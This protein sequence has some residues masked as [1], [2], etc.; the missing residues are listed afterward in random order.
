MLGALIVVSILFIYV[1]WNY[2]R[3]V[4]SMRVSL[5]KEQAQRM[6]E[7]AKAFQREQYLITLAYSAKPELASALANTPLPF[8]QEEQEEETTFLEG[9]GFGR[10]GK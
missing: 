1:I 3:V 6:K 2:T 7:R 8:E 9:F 4:E 10:T 5:F